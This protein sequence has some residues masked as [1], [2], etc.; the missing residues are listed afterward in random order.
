[1]NNR[2]VLK[3]ATKQQYKSILISLTM[4][5][6]TAVILSIIFSTEPKAQK[7]GATK[8]TPMLV[9]TITVSLQDNT[10]VIRAYGSVV[11][12]QSVDLKP[13]VSGTVQAVSENFVPGNFVRQGE[14]LIKLDPTDYQLAVARAETQMIKAESDYQIELGEQLRAQKAYELVSASV[15]SENKALILREPQKLQA[16]A[17]LKS[18]KTTLTQAQLALERTI[19]RMPFDGQILTRES[20]IGSQLSLSE[21]IAKL[22]GTNSYWIEASVPLSQV[23]NLVLPTQTEQ[24]IPVTIRNKTTWKE[25]QTISGNLIQ[26]ISSLDTNTRMAKVLIEVIDPLGLNQTDNN[27]S[28]P[29]LIAGTY[30]ESELKI[31]NIPESVKLN[32]RHLRK[33]NSVWVY[34]EGKLDI[35][36]VNVAFRDDQHAYITQGLNDG[37]KVI[38]T[39]I[40]RVRAGADVQLK[41][42]ST[43][44]LN[45]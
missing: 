37:D 34:Q 4:I 29:P 26:V 22:I 30:V 40:S 33:G 7:D 32:V 36:N 19:I 12:S 31:K 9:D 16:E 27:I 35:R 5:V 17:E 24:N 1:M 45:Q 3:M 15:A 28:R 41:S 6:I 11:P 10:P 13:R 20:N 42:S 38:I 18:A 43:R 23:Q 14:W 8:R 2:S 39:D 44:L 21:V 25:N